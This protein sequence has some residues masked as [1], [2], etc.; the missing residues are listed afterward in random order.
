MVKN[1]PSHSGDV[2][3]SPDRG[4]MIPRAGDSELHVLRLLSPYP[5][6]RSPCAP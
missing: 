6:V 5:A 4:T 1:L 2:G 3:S